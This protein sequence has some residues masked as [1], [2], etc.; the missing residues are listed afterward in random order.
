MTLRTTT[1]RPGIMVVLRTNIIGNVK[2]SK[3]VIE[4]DTE[5]EGGG[6][7]AKWETERFITNAAELKEATQVRSKVRNTIA[8]LCAQT[9]FG[10]LCP[11]DKEDKL[12]AAY[13]ESLAL[14]EAFNDRAE[15]TK[16][17][18]YMVPGKVAADDVR[19]VRAINSE[20]RELMETMEK[21]LQNLNPKMVRDAA[22]RA[23]SLGAMLSPE[24]S[25]RVA[26]ALK[27]AR[28]AASDIVKA[29]EVGGAEI[30]LASIRKIADARTS[31]LD[32]DDAKEVAA[33]VHEA[34]ALDLAPV[35]SGEQPIAPAPGQTVP[36]F[37][38]E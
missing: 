34:R 26:G 15:T 24:M 9:S 20:V 14:V 21:G 3:T 28:K 10:L 33:P 25:E 4:P 37:E 8:N 31:F 23:R 38:M 32:L 17:T 7:K 35:E 18:F 6:Q 13:N 27:V 1:I 5:T 30:D 29:A 22:D 36:A 19:A 2:Y 11:E 16:I 12:D